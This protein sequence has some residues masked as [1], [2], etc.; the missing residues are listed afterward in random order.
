MFGSNAAERK[1]LVPASADDS[2]IN[3]YK[4]KYRWSDY[5]DYI[6]EEE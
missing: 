6:F 3:A 4:A 5:A 1:I 2:I